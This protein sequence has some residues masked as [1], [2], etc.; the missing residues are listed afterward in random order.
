[1]DLIVIVGPTAVGKTKLSIEVTK[2]FD[3][4]IISGDAM[5]FYKGLDIGT[6]KAS[7]AEQTQV[8]HHLLDILEP[9]ESFSVVEY[10]KLV[11]EKI[12][13][14]KLKN[15]TPILVGGS[16]LYVQSIIEDYQFKGA[17]RDKDNDYLNMSL[18][19]LQNKLKQKNPKLYE[20]I[21]IE[22]K[23]RVIRALEKDDDDIQVERKPYYD[24]YYI[25]GLNTNREKLYERINNRVDDMIKS[26]LIDEVK[27]LYDQNIRSQ[28]IKAIGYKELYQYFDGDI[29]LDESIRLIKRNSRR[30]AKR[31]LTWFRNK[32]NVEWF[33][34]HIENFNQTIDEVMKQIKKKLNQ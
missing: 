27:T 4:E 30:Y 11:R 17:K 21:D 14:I 26:G 19:L 15:K 13:E 3:G 33:E 32:M 5:Q 23:R 34:S 8:K 29:S 16:G 10:Q 28:S 18:D 24:N 31:Q 22:N 1:M 25:I 2:A 7:K 9:T 12:T 6:A 20:Q